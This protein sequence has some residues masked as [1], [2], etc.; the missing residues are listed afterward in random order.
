MVINHDDPA[1]AGSGRWNGSGLGA[2]FDGESTTLL[3]SLAFD[4]RVELSEGALRAIRGD[5]WIQVRGDAEAGFA[6]YAEALIGRWGSRSGAI[7]PVWCSWYSYWQHIDEELLTQTLA[8]VSRLP[9]QVFQVDAGW[10]RGLGDWRANAKFPRGM[11]W[12]S[13]QIE[14]AGLRPGLWLAPF[15]VHRQSDLALSYPQFLLADDRGV[16]VRFSHN[17]G[18]DGLAL[19]VARADVLEYLQETMKEVVSWGYSYLKLDFLYAAAF[20]SKSDRLASR[21]MDYRRAVEAI[22]SAVGEEIYLLACGAPVLASIGVFDAI[23]IGP[24]TA[25]YWEDESRTHRLSDWSAPAARNALQTS[26]HRLWLATAIGLD[27][28]VSFFRSRYNLLS[29]EQREWG[30]D[31]ALITGFRSTSDPPAWLDREEIDELVHYLTYTP[32]ISKVDAYRWQIADRMIDFEP[33]LL[34]VGVK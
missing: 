15:A 31:L 32:S 13:E 25:P 1:F 30:Q 9:F 19:D 12:L 16:P 29:P 27:P 2:L 22:R 10:E 5:D 7:G 28:D 23:R 33:A 21:E 6:R 26:L 11:A 17:W 14:E 34:S 3:G 4:G 20:P 8:E 24:D 18:N